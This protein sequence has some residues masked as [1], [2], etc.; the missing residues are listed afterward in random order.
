MRIGQRRSLIMKAEI[1][2]YIAIQKVDA[3]IYG[4]MPFYVWMTREKSLEF[5]LIS[6]PTYPQHFIVDTG[7]EYGRP[8]QRYEVT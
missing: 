4:S 3:I 1:F 8:A 5:I 7:Q 2:R 6:L